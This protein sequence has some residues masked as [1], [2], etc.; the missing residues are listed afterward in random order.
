MIVQERALSL[1]LGR[2][3]QPLIIRELAGIAAIDTAIANEPA[4]DTIVM[5]H[6]AKN[7]KQANVEQLA[8]LLRMHGGQPDEG[9]SFRKALTRSKTAVAARVSTKAVLR[10]MQHAEID[11]VSR[12][13]DAIGDAKGVVKQALTKALGRALI[14]AHLLTA[15]LARHT[16]NRSDA[17]LLPLPLEHYFVGPEPRACMRCHLDRP[18]RSGA[19]ERTDPNPYTYV[20]AACHDEVLGEFSVD[21]AEQMEHW[22]RAMREA[23]VIQRALGRVSKLNAI[24]RVLHPLYGLEHDL[25][26]AAAERAV[27][28]PAMTP[29]PGPADGERT[30][31][32]KVETRND[33][34]GAYIQE[35]FAVRGVWR[36]W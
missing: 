2:Q 20:C 6:D 4:P 3:L 19:L 23:K 34:E 32:V 12:Y 10:S 1:G 30:G 31:V 15:H 25:P 28:A 35:L 17:R 5:F 13:S 21:I 22:S 16:A 24:G 11:L 26:T 27:I 9:A 29:T 36:H 14:Q 33:A 18:G 7:G 8:T